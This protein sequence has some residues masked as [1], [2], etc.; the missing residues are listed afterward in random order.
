MKL[1]GLT[2]GIACGK[3]TL[4]AL[5][6]KKGAAIIDADLL[7]RE[8]YSDPN[9]TSQ[10][11]ALFAG[12][13]ILDSSGAIDRARLS[14][15]VFGNAQLLRKLE[16]VVHPAV[17]ALRDE[18]LRELKGQN[19]PPEVVVLEAVKLIESGQARDCREVWCVMCSPQT[20]L[21]RLMENRSLSE[22]EARARLATQPPFEE[23]QRI[24][25]ALGIALIR[26]E[27]EGSLAA[28][29]ARVQ[30]QWNQLLEYSANI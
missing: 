6:R 16:L 21:R 1:L 5:L 26:I 22:D 11:A 13:E 12:Q 17:A 27:N 19:K 4:A 23:K 15:L 28:M 30:Q 3:S 7:V 2:G 29:E 8:L 25:D 10:V 14:T 9:F 18:K 20:Q 24:L